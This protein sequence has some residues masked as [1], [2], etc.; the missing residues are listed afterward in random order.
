MRDAGALRHV[1]AQ[2]RLIARGD[3]LALLLYAVKDMSYEEIARTLRVSMSAVK[4][5]I[6]RARQALQHTE[7]RGAGNMLGKG[8]KK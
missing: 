3:R 2:L 4:S 7:P 1:R 6:R 5:R 8:R